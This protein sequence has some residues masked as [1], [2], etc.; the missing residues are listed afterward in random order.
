MCIKKYELFTLPMNII[1]VSVI[2]R[3]EYSFKMSVV[4]LSGQ[5]KIKGIN[6]KMSF[7]SDKIFKINSI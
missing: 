7:F 6:L 5:I 3:K 1:D 2:V 4:L